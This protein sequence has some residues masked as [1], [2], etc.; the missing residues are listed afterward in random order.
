[1]FVG[2]IVK[3]LLPD[4]QRSREFGRTVSEPRIVASNAHEQGALMSMH[5]RQRAHDAAIALMRAQP[6]HR[7]EIPVADAER[8]PD[9]SCVSRIGLGR[10]THTLG[11]D[12][13]LLSRYAVEALR[14]IGG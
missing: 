10:D 4:A 2:Q 7:K 8:F 9:S 1:L 3:T 6:T 14:V 13:Q 5:P 11:D 12:T